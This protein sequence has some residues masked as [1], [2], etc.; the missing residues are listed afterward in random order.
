MSKY[1]FFD[2]KGR[3]SKVEADLCKKINT[4]L[5]SGEIEQSEIDN[6]IDTDGYPT[7]AEELDILYSYLSGESGDEQTNSV[8][9]TKTEYVEP[10]KDI[11]DNELQSDVNQDFGEETYSEIKGQKNQKAVGFDP[12]AEPVIERGYTK[13]FNIPNEQDEETQNREGVQF[14]E[15][16]FDKPQEGESVANDLNGVSEAQEIEEDIPQPEWVESG[17]FDEEPEGENDEFEEG[18]EEYEDD[19]KLGDGNLDDLSPA[20]KRKS[21]EKT[22]DAILQMY[23][24][25]APLPFKSWASFKDNTIQKMV[26]DGRLDL[27]MQLENG[28]TVKDYIDS[29]NEQVEDIFEVTEET[30][31]EIKDPLVEVLLEQEIALTPTQRLMIAVGSHVVQMGFSAYQLSQNNKVAL[32]SFEKFHDQMKKPNPNYR[33]QPNTAKQ[34]NPVTEERINDNDKQAVDELMREINKDDDGIIDAENDPSVEVTVEENE[35]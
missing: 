13:G 1:P 19:G 16:D 35:D 4:L 15:T 17:G 23:S 9:Q 20:Q 10:S 32:E 24:K 27:N 29:Q 6:I 22:A 21:A 2:K 14:D 3:P 18:D 5:N 12:F 31:Q 26:I 25:F 33:Q 7:N 30:Q 11:D 28:V 8:N 34:P